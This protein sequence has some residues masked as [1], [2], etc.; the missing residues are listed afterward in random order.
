MIVIKFKVMGQQLS[1]IDTK[2][3]VAG[4][5]NELFVRFILDDV[6]NE[7][8]IVTAQFTGGN[9][10]V[11]VIVDNGICMIPWE[12]LQERGVLSVCLIGGDLITT[13]TVDIS[14]LS[15]GVIG[16]LVPTAASP[17]VYSYILEIADNIKNDWINCKSLLDTYKSD[18]NDKK[19]ELQDQIEIIDSKVDSISIML[20]DSDTKLSE[21]DKKYKEIT[22][23]I[24]DFLA[25]FDIIKTDAI[26]EIEENIA[27]VTATSIT[28]LNE[29]VDT[30]KSDIEKNVEIVKECSKDMLTI[31]IKYFDGETDTF[32][33]LLKDSGGLEGKLELGQNEGDATLYICKNGNTYLW[34]QGLMANGDESRWTDVPDFSQCNIGDLYVLRRGVPNISRDAFYGCVGI[35]NVY[36]PES[37]T[38]IGSNVFLGSSIESIIIPDNIKDIGYNTFRD[39]KNL[40]RINIP[41]GVTTLYNNV[42]RG[43]SSL[44]SIEIPNSVV[45][46]GNYVME[47][48][49]SL[50]N[51]T[52]PESVE[53]IGTGTFSN[54]V[55]LSKI[56][57]NKTTDSITGAPWGAAK[58]EIIW[59][60]GNGSGEN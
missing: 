37:V 39:C 12:V 23:L 54:C 53:T 2:N 24:A 14:V 25:E 15:T 46:I 26:A 33:I 30:A 36:L 52:I 22:D 41:Y 48:C 5:R 50:E 13:N 56:I 11:D 60:G 55:K 35:K 9:T 19:Q 44:K 6:W 58:A 45:T 34:G 7:K 40:I 21:A 28:E 8:D 32:D 43:C 38:S 49:T 10:T 17:S 57:I 27:N 42:L 47:G 1:R 16:G 59:T 20:S 3:I 29:V 31:P 51:I 4:S 18:I